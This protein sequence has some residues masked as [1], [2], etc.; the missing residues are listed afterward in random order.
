MEAAARQSLWKKPS[1]SW[2]YNDG[3][4]LMLKIPSAN[5]SIMLGSCTKDSSASS[6]V[7]DWGDGSSNTY[8]NSTFSPSHTYASSGLFVL[9]ISDGISSMTYK[10]TNTSGTVYMMLSFGTK[11]LTLP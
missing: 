4:N 3:T 10:G 7:V 5:Y 8:S 2:K 11:L 6:V 9:N 1:S